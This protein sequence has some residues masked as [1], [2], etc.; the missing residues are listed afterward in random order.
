MFPGYGE[1]KVKLK[2]EGDKL[3]A[4]LAS[5]S[6]AE[7]DEE[8]SRTNAEVDDVDKGSLASN[9]PDGDSRDHVAAAAA[10]LDLPDAVHLASDLHAA[11]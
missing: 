3:A 5:S 4:A 6:A 2:E 10:N 11:T 7:A 1:K 8:L 9:G